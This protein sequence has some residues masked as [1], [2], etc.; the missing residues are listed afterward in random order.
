MPPYESSRSVVRASVQLAEVAASGRAVVKMS[1]LALWPD[2]EIVEVAAVPRGDGWHRVKLDDRLHLLHRA[3]AGAPVNVTATAVSEAF[4]HPVLLRGM[5]M[6]VGG[7][8]HSLTRGQL[9]VF[10]PTGRK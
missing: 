8:S 6:V 4:G 3:D 9:A 7:Q 5:V 1:A 10:V 2:G